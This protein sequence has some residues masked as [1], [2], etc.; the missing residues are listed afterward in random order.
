MKIVKSDREV[1]PTIGVARSKIPHIPTISLVEGKNVPQ[2]E[3]RAVVAEA[4]GAFSEQQVVLSSAE[5]L[6]LIEAMANLGAGEVRSALGRTLSSHV[7]ELVRLTAIA[8]GTM[9]R[10]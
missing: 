6:R 2:I 1:S 8:S 7:R 10:D 3:F 9:P 4:E 5:L